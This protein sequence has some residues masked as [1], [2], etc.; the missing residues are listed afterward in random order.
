MGRT[1]NYID[2]DAELAAAG[3]E[4]ALPPLVVA[5]PAGPEPATFDTY[6]TSLDGPSRHDGRG[7]AC[8]VYI[9]PTGPLM[10]RRYPLARDPVVIGRSDDCAIPNNDGSVSRHHARVEVRQDGRYHVTDLGSTNGTFV[11]NA[12]KVESPLQDGDYLRIGNCIYRFLG[13]GNLEAEYHEEI[14]RLTVL[15]PLTGVPNRRHFQEFVDREVAR[16]ARHHRPLALALI[17]ID[18]FKAINDSMGH[19][20]GDLTLRQL[21]SSVGG[22]IRR[23][24]LFARY[25][26]EEFAIVLPELDE[27]QAVA[28]GERV[29]RT[30]AD[31]DFAFGGRRYKVTVSVGVAATSGGEAVQ[32]ADLLRRADD[33]LYK[34]KAAGRNRVCP[35]PRPGAAEPHID[36]V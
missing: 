16:A 23:D 12:I 2:L 21:A 26:G 30:V 34:A 20:A 33:M 32:T 19:L 31:Q 11:N 7:E 22:T 18:H 9:Y 28:V 5:A 35:A 8:L 17:D 1:H 3:P 4:F 27:A 24:E 29:R 6:K 14:Y 15:D 13:G 10:G 25:G 36:H